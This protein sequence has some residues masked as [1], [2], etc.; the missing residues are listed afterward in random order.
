MTL[1]HRHRCRHRQDGS[2]RYTYSLYLHWH[3]RILTL[4]LQ[5]HQWTPHP[6]G[7]FIFARTGQQ[8]VLDGT[9]GLSSS[10]AVCIVG[11]CGHAHCTVVFAIAQLSCYN[12]VHDCKP[13]KSSWLDWDAIWVV[14]AVGQRNHVLDGELEPTLGGGLC[15]GGCFAHLIALHFPI[16]RL[17]CWPAV[18]KQDNIYICMT[19]Y[20]YGNLL[21]YAV[22]RCS[23]LQQWNWHF[24]EI[25]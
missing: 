4:F 9:N 19:W 20:I 16:Q 12:L 14:T 18:Q 15:R 10:T 3:L 17:M 22:Y 23:S 1:P 25:R 24:W 8:S 21:A 6:T 13:Y 5:F 2:R 7:S 11:L